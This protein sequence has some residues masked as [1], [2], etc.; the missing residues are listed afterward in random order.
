MIS[1]TFRIALL[2]FTAFLHLQAQPFKNLNRYEAVYATYTNEE[3]KK[4]NEAGYLYCNP[5][6]G[7]PVS[8]DDLY[9]LYPFTKGNIPDTWLGMVRT[10]LS[11]ADKTEYLVV[12]D[13]GMSDDYNF[14]FFQMLKD[15]LLPLQTLNPD[16]QKT[17]AYIW[18][19]EIYLPGN[20]YFYT[21]GHVNNLF[22]Q[23]S[24]WAIANNLLEETAQ[25]F[26]YVGLETTAKEPI[27]IYADTG[28][29]QKVADIAAG[30]ALTV[31]LNLPA[32]QAPAS[33]EDAANGYRRYQYFLLKTE[34]GLAG[35]VKI[36]SY[37]MQTPIEGLFFAGD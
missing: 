30:N 32:E 29:T 6:L 19:K 21:T 8:F 35:W 18:G 27:T 33:A 3:G 1:S 7:K 37:S 12:F 31:L 13:W 24:K 17:D 36:D 25:P 14:A 9:H 20:G 16:G 2:L 11:A 10:K 28:L 4:V 22:N 26:Y 15:T 34:F 23:R 5:A